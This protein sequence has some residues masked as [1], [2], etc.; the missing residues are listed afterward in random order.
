MNN[1][2]LFGLCLALGT[3][4]TLSAQAQSTFDFSFGG[5]SVVHHTPFTIDGYVTLAASSGET[6]ATG[7]FITYVS[8]A[9]QMGLYEGQN[10]NWVTGSGINV[11]YN[12]FE[13][14]NGAITFDTF[15]A[16]TG[17]PNFNVFNIQG[18][19]D[20][21]FDTD[22]FSTSQIEAAPEPT[23]LALVG[24]GALVPLFRRRK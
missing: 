6:T 9:Y 11:L 18:D 19:L 14:A 24:M 23:T 22:P 3:V 13:V 2:H 21:Y 5:T 15:Y 12:D 1:K 8:N 17:S 4:A 20:G 16:S 7:L 10:F